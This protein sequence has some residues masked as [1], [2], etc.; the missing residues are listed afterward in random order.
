MARGFKIASGF[1]DIGVDQK[2]A[3][4]GL[5]N[6]TKKLGQVAKAAA[7]AGA[8]LAAA[9][10]AF[11]IKEAA[12]AEAVRA[13]LAAVLKATGNA[14]GF[15]A[16]ELDRQATALQNMTGISD[17]AI[18]RGQTILATFTQI[19]EKTFPRAT[20]AVL[21]LASVL[22]DDAIPAAG[23]IRSAALQLGK[24]LN[25]P[26]L[27]MT[28]LGR[29]GIQFTKAQK[30]MVKVLV[31]SNQTLAAQELILDE[32]EKQF[33]GVAKAVG[34]TAAADFARF[35]EELS[36]L[37]AEIGSELMPAVLLLLSAIKDIATSDGVVKWARNSV[38]GLGVLITTLTETVEAMQTA[39]DIG[40]TVNA[41]GSFRTTAATKREIRDKTTDVNEDRAE[42]RKADAVDK[43]RDKRRKAAQES[44]KAFKEAAKAAKELKE[45][46]ERQKDAA[47]LWLKGGNNLPVFDKLV[48]E[49]E[50]RLQKM[51]DALGGGGTTSN[52]FTGLDEAFRA[53]STQ[54]DDTGEQQVKILEK[55]LEELE[56]ANDIAE[57][58][59]E[60]RG[61]NDL[62]VWVED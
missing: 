62:V 23:E 38:V 9:A 22:S 58:I 42:Q 44:A 46:A 43:E 52:T 47:E 36:D 25:D 51:I 59:A 24:A 7:V 37:A 11:S 54:E 61:D 5:D 4:K 39:K 50:E 12:K 49:D 14:A 16:D 15:T 17:E 30:D 10:V 20:E 6:L 26:V 31:D 33:G 27:G 56:K 3:T 28:A 21:D 45:A 1:L 29:A 41:D 55:Q 35:K 48:P 60:A 34:K 2:N 18:L 57:R 8:A 13:K 53:F 32:V 40:L 19:G